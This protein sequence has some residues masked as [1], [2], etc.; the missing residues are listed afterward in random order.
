MKF[1]KKLLSNYYL[2]M[3]IVG[4]LLIV[5]ATALLSVVAAIYV[6]GGLLLVWG[7]LDE[8]GEAAVKKVTGDKNGNR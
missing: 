5:L 6:A 3:Q 8:F 1:F 2:V 4:C 7:I